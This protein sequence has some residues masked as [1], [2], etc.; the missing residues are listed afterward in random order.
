M[1]HFTQKNSP[2]AVCYSDILIL[3][4]FR[5]KPT[6]LLIPLSYSEGR[7]ASHYVTLLFFFLFF[8][9]KKGGGTDVPELRS[10]SSFTVHPTDE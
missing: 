4:K 7:T 1:L 9:W 3:F 5:K 6:M 10:A 2:A 8:F